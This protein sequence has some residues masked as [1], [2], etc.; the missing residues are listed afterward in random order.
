M[1]AGTAAST[2]MRTPD[3]WA[4]GERA[5]GTG[6]AEAARMEGEGDQ[7]PEASA[8]HLGRGGFRCEMLGDVLQNWAN[9]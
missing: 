7:G 1:A 3:P 5:S 9:S 6:A 4:E 8:S 2:R